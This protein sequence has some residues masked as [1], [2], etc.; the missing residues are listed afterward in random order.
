MLKDKIEADFKEALKTQDKYATQTLRMLKAEIF[1]REKEKRYKLS[2]EKPD[3]SDKELEKESLAQDE[4]V[5]ETILSKI[6]KGKESISEFKKGQRQDLVEKEEKEIKVLTK[7]LPEQLPE[8]E[9]EKMAQEAIEQIGAKEIKDMG[10]V[11]A[12][13]M[14][15]TKGKTDPALVSKIVKGLLLEHD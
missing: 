1:N 14:P 5:L 2:K 8:K 6:K 15:K 3:L 12:Q 11:M 10:K 7:Y 4:E 9:I 13:L